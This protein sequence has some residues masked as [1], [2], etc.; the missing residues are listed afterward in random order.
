MIGMG[1]G[2]GPINIE[3]ARKMSRARWALAV[4]VVLAV[5]AFYWFVWPTQWNYGVQSFGL[6]DGRV[7]P[8]RVNRLTGRTEWY[9]VGWR[10]P[11]RARSAGRKASAAV[12]TEPID[13]ELAAIARR[14]KASAKVGE[15]SAFDALDK[16]PEIRRGKPT[17]KPRP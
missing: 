1:Y 5:V 14:Q 16:L 15:N 13:P 4:V 10:D 6:G 7:F 11:S 8:L 12:V 17:A 2:C 3:E 9:I